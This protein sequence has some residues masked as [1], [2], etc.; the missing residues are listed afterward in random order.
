MKW[1]IKKVK[2]RNECCWCKKKISD[3][4]PVYGLNAKF[5]KGVESPPVEDEGYIIELTVQKNMDSAEYKP[6]RAIV[7][8]KNSDAKKAEVD[9]IF[10]FCSEE[11]GRELKEILQADIGFLDKLSEEGY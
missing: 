8:G 11:C 5:R 1:H 7:T 3:Y 10:M 4:S 2:Y 6:V 9:M